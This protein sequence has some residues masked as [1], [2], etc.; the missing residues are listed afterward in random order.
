MGGGAVRQQRDVEATGQHDVTA[1]RAPAPI[2]PPVA[3]GPTVENRVFEAKKHEIQLDRE[4]EE[5]QMQ[6]VV[7]S[8]KDLRAR[9][10]EL[11]GRAE[12]FGDA[13]LAA[14]AREGAANLR[15]SAGLLEQARTA[16]DDGRL[17][18]SSSLTDRATLLQRAARLQEH[19]LDEAKLYGYESAPPEVRHGFDSLINT[20]GRMDNDVHREKITSTLDYIREHDALLNSGA[21]GMGDTRRRLLGQVDRIASIL[22]AGQEMTPQL[23]AEL[24]ARFRASIVPVQNMI[25]GLQ[26]ASAML[27]K[28]IGQTGKRSKDYLDELKE[29]K[30]ELEKLKKDAGEEEKAKAAEKAA[31]V[32]DAETEIEAAPEE[33]R[34]GL[35][36]IYARGL[37]S[38]RSGKPAAA[39]FQAEIAK[40]FARA[41]PAGRDM[42]ESISR[43]VERGSLSVQDG[44]GLLRREAELS[45]IE[46][47][48]AGAR[49]QVSKHTE[50]IRELDRKAIELL[51]KADA[52]RKRGDI[53][54]ALG[55]EKEA[56]GLLKE[57]DAKTEGLKRIAEMGEMLRRAG[58]PEPL[59]KAVDSAFRFIGTA[60]DWRG[61]LILRAGQ[62]FLDNKELFK[63]KNANPFLGALFRFAQALAGPKT[64][65]QIGGREKAEAYFERDLEP[66]TIE[67]ALLDAG[68]PAELIKAVKAAAGFMGTAQQWRGVMIIKAARAFLQ[69][70]GKL[71]FQKGAKAREGL[72][73]FIR[74]LASPDEDQLDEREMDRQFEDVL[75]GIAGIPREAPGRAAGG[76]RPVKAAAPAV[77]KAGLE[78]EY[79]E[80]LSRFGETEGIAAQVIAAAREAKK[81]IGT[82]QEWRAKLALET[83]ELYQSRKAVLSKPES[84]GVFKGICSLILTLGD[85]ARR[86]DGKKAQGFLDRFRLEADGLEKKARV[87]DTA[88]SLEEAGAP[89]EIAK[90]V[91]DA[92]AFAG[93]ADEWRL[94]LALEAA[95]LY[96]GK[97]NVFASKYGS[98]ALASFLNFVGAISDPSLKIDKDKA[99]TDFSAFSNGVDSL[100][101]DMINEYKRSFQ[102]HK[103]TLLK[104]YRSAPPEFRPAIDA[105]L[106]AADEMIGRLGNGENVRDDD[107]AWLGMRI[108][109]L[110]QVVPKIDGIKDKELRKQAMSAYISAFTVLAA[111]KNYREFDILIFAAEEIEG[112]GGKEFKRYRDDLV[113]RSAGVASAGSDKLAEETEAVVRL[114]SSSVS[115]EIKTVAAGRG[116]QTQEIVSPIADSVASLAD[117][118][119]KAVADDFYR[120]RATLNIVKEMNDFLSPK[121]RLD[122]SI[123]SGAET[124]WD[125]GLT[126]IRQGGDVPTALSQSFLAKQF[127]KPRLAQGIRDEIEGLSRALEQDPGKAAQVGQYLEIADK[128]SGYRENMKGL[129]KEAQ[130]VLGRITSELES[131]ARLIASGADMLSADQAASA[132]A[133]VRSSMEQDPEFGRYVQGFAEQNNIPPESAV[134]LVARQK[135]FSELT[136]TA[137]MMIK[138]PEGYDSVNG[139]QRQQYFEI[140]GL[141][142]DAMISGE[143]GR[144]GIYRDAA[145]TYTKLVRPADRDDLASV[146]REYSRGVLSQE[147]AGAYFSVYRERS[148]YEAKITDK[149]LRANATAYFDLAMVS[150]SS[151]NI[152]DH[153]FLMEM[154][155]GYASW[156][157]MDPADLG[158]EDRKRREDSLRFYEGQLGDFSRMRKRITDEGW[159]PADGDI[160]APIAGAI[161]IRKAPLAEALGGGDL[162]AGVNEI[163]RIR[164]EAGTRMAAISDI[165]FGNKARKAVGGNEDGQDRLRKR[166]KRAGDWLGSRSKQAAADKL[167]GLGQYFDMHSPLISYDFVASSVETAKELHS[168]AK[169]E[170]DEALGLNRQADEALAAGDAKNAEGLR[171]LAMAHARNGLM[172]DRK[173]NDI[174]DGVVMLNAGVGLSTKNRESGWLDLGIGIKTSIAIGRGFEAD[175]F[176][177]IVVR[178]GKEVPID[179]SHVPKLERQA[180]T[181]QRSGTQGVLYQQKVERTVDRGVSNAKKEIRDRN[182]TGISELIDRLIELRP[183][184]EEKASL[185]ATKKIYLE[186]ARSKD[187]QEAEKGINDLQQLYQDLAQSA[188]VAKG[189]AD[190]GGNEVT[191]YDAVDYNKRYWSVVG[192][193]YNEDFTGAARESE[194]TQILM[195][196]GFDLA[197]NRITE[198]RLRLE[199]EPL[200]SEEGPRVGPYFG[201]SALNTIGYS[202][203]DEARF[204]VVDEIGSHIGSFDGIDDNTKEILKR[205]IEEIR[206]MPSGP[207]RNGKVIDFLNLVR[208]TTVKGRVLFDPVGGGLIGSGDLIY[209]DAGANE[210]ELLRARGMA[211]SGDLEPAKDILANAEPEMELGAAIQREDN[212]RLRSKVM[213]LTI[214]K[215][216]DNLE[217]ELPPAVRA[218]DGRGKAE[219]EDFE[220]ARAPLLNAM[221][222]SRYR[223]ADHWAGAEQGFEESRD[224]I[225]KS[226]KIY[227]PTPETIVGIAYNMSESNLNMVLSNGKTYAQMVKEVETATTPDEKRDKA[228]E[229]YQTMMTESPSLVE[230]AISDLQKRRTEGWDEV[231]KA[232]GKP[233]AGG[234]NL[235]PEL[236][237]R[238]IHLLP[239]DVWKKKKLGNGLTYRKMMVEVLTANT[240][241]EKRRA[242]EELFKALLENPED[243]SAVFDKVKAR[244]Q[245]L[246]NI[247][248]DPAFFKPILAQARYQNVDQMQQQYKVSWAYQVS[249]YKKFDEEVRAYDNAKRG[250]IGQPDE[251][252]YVAGEAASALLTAASGQNDYRFFDL[253]KNGQ[254][255]PAVEYA[256]RASK[257]RPWHDF[258]YLRIHDDK[259]SGGARPRDENFGTWLRFI[260]YDSGQATSNYIIAWDYDKR[261]E[262]MSRVS[263]QE[264]DFELGMLGVKRTERGAQSAYFIND[265]DKFAAWNPNERDFRQ[266]ADSFE[267]FMNVKNEMLGTVFGYEDSWGKNEEESLLEHVG[268]RMGNF[269]ESGVILQRDGDSQKNYGDS[270]IAFANG[271][272]F[273]RKKVTI[274][275]GELA[276]ERFTYEDP[277]QTTKK[278]IKEMY[279]ERSAHNSSRMFWKILR[280]GAEYALS[281]F[282]F[283]I[284][285]AAATA[286]LTYDGLDSAFTYYNRAGGW[287]YMSGSQKGF[288]VFQ[289]GMAVLPAKMHLMGSGLRA[290]RLGAE[291]AELSAAELRTAGLG[292]IAAGERVLAWEGKILI[293]AGI[294]QVAVELPDMWRAY[295]RGEM[296]GLEIFMTGAQTVM[297][298]IQ[299]A[300]HA[301]RIAAMKET[302]L[303]T[304]RPRWRQVVE[305]LAFGEPLDPVKEHRIAKAY[306][307]V[308]REFNRLESADQASYNA[309]K[310]RYGV[311]FKAEEES[312]FLRKFREARESGRFVDFEHFAANTPEV[313][314][315]RYESVMYSV[316]GGKRSLSSVSEEEFVYLDARLKGRSQAEAMAS[317]DIHYAETS[318]PEAR[319]N[320]QAFFDAFVRM[321]RSPE[322][323]TMPER[324]YA[325]SRLKGMEPREAMKAYEAAKAELPRQTLDDLGRAALEREAAEADAVNALVAKTASALIG[326]FSSVKERDG[327]KVY[328]YGEGEYAIDFTEEHVDAATKLAYYANDYLSD[329]EISGVA[330]HEAIGKIP[331]RYREA[332]AGLAGDPDFAKAA[333]G[334][335]RNAQLRLGLE[336][337]AKIPQLASKPEVMR[338]AYSAEVLPIISERSLSSGDIS[339]FARDRRAEARERREKA[340]QLEKE[341]GSAEPLEAGSLRARA[342]MLKARA[343]ALDISAMMLER[344][345]GHREAPV[346]GEIPVAPERK[347]SA[348]GTEAKVVVAKDEKGSNTLELLVADSPQ[349]V[350]DAARFLEKNVPSDRPLSEEELAR[351]PF[352]YRDAAALMAGESPERKLLW[353]ADPAFKAEDAKKIGQKILFDKRASGLESELKVMEADPS[354]AEDARGFLAAI[355]GQDLPYELARKYMDASLFEEYEKAKGEK[356]A[357]GMSEDRAEILAVIEVMQRRGTEPAEPEP[358]AVP[359][360]LIGRYRKDISG[361]GS[362][363]LAAKRIRSEGAM[364]Q[365]GKDILVVAEAKLGLRKDVTPAD[366]AALSSEWGQDRLAVLDLLS[367]EGSKFRERFLLADPVERARI[368][369][370]ISSGM[371]PESAF[372]RISEEFMPA[373]S[374]ELRDYSRRIGSLPQ[375]ER[376][377]R[378]RD[379]LSSNE[380]LY[381]TLSALISEGTSPKMK[382]RVIAEWDRASLE[383]L[384]YDRAEAARKARTKG[385]KASQELALIKGTEKDYAAGVVPGMIGEMAAR[386]GEDP[387]AF[388][389]RLAKAYGDGGKKGQLAVI[390]M[391]GVLGGMAQGQKQKF[392]DQNPEFFDLLMRGDLEG[393]IN[394]L[395]GFRGLRIESVN[396]ELGARGSYSVKLSDGR[397]VFVKMES[398]E[399]ARFGADLAATQGLLPPLTHADDAAGRPLAYD[400]GVRFE[401]PAGGTAP[402]LQEFGIMEDVHDWAGKTVELKMPDGRREKVEVLSVAMMGPEV[403]G[404]SSGFPGDDPRNMAIT[405]FYDLARTPEGRAKLYSSWRAYIEMSRRALLIDRFDRNTEVIVV[406]RGDGSTEVLFQPIDMDFIGGRIKRFSDGALDLNAFNDDF[407]KATMGFAQ[408]LSKRSGTPLDKVLGE[409]ISAYEGGPAMASELPAERKASDDNRS[410]VIEGHDGKV[411]GFG[412]DVRSEGR[413]IGRTPIE[414]GGRVRVIER[415]DARMLMY[416]DELNPLAIHVGSAEGETAY[417]R[418]LLASLKEEKAQADKSAARRVKKPAQAPA[419]VERP[420]AKTPPM[421]KP[422]IAEYRPQ[423]KPAEVPPGFESTPPQDAGQSIYA[424]EL[425]GH[426]E[427]LAE[428]AVGLVRGDEAAVKRLASLKGHPA[429]KILERMVADI[430][431]DRHYIKAVQKNDRVGMERFLKF[432]VQAYAIRYAEQLA[433][434]VEIRPA[435]AVAVGEVLPPPRTTPGRRAAAPE[436]KAPGIPEFY[437]DPSGAWKK[438]E[439]LPPIRKA[440]FIGKVAEDYIEKAYVAGDKES[441]SMYENLP[442]DMKENFD[443]TVKR[444][445]AMRVEHGDETVISR[446]KERPD[447]LRE[448]VNEGYIPEGKIISGEPVA[449]DQIIEEVHPEAVVT[450]KGLPPALGP[451]TEGNVLAVFSSGSDLQT[452]EA[453]ARTFIGMDMQAQ[454]A[455]IDGL[456]SRGVQGEAAYLSELRGIAGESGDAIARIYG[457][458]K[459]A[460]IDIYA[461]SPDARSARHGLAKALGITVMPFAWEGTAREHR[462]WVSKPYQALDTSWDDGFIFGMIG[463]GDLIGA[464]GSAFPGARISYVEYHNGAVGAYEV[465]LAVPLP[466]GRTE[467]R[468][469]FVKRQDLRPDA[470]GAE[471]SLASGIPAPRVFTSAGGHEL[472]YNAPDG[473]VSRYGIMEDIKTFEGE[474]K[475]GGGSVKVRTVD[476]TALWDLDKSPLL[477]MF[478]SAD[479]QTRERFWDELGYTL[480]GSYATGLWDRHAGNARAMVLEV[481]NPGAKLDAADPASL[482][483]GDALRQKGYHVWEKDGKTLMFMIGGIDNDTGASFLAGEFNGSYDFSGMNYRYGMVDLHALFKRLAAIRG[484]SVEKLVWEAFG[485]VESGKL[486]GPLARGASRWMH[487]IGG[488][489]GYIEGMKRMFASHDG[490]GV[491]LG[492]PYSPDQQAR[493][494]QGKPVHIE[495]PQNGDP[496]TLIEF[497]DGRSKLRTDY[498][499][500]RSDVLSGFDPAVLAMFPD[501]RE[502]YVVELTRQALGKMPGIDGAVNTIRTGD[503]RTLAV[504][505]AMDPF[506]TQLADSGLPYLKAR[507]DVPNPADVPNTDPAGLIRADPGFGALVG[508]QVSRAGAIPVFESMMN[509]G[510]AFLLAQFGEVGRFVIATEKRVN[511]QAPKADIAGER[512]VPEAPAPKLERLADADAAM[513][514]L[515][516][517]YRAGDPEGIVKARQAYEDKLRLAAKQMPE[518]PV[519][520]VEAAA[521]LGD[522]PPMKVFEGRT[523]LADYLSRKLGGG[524]LSGDAL[525][526]QRLVD[527]GM[528]PEVAAAV[529]A[530]HSD[531]V[532]SAKIP[533][534]GGQALERYSARNINEISM[535]PLAERGEAMARFLIA[536]DYLLSRAEAD[537]RRA[538]AWFAFMEDNPN[539]V[540]Y[541]MIAKRGMAVSGEGIHF[542]EFRV[543]K[544]DAAARKDV[545]RKLAKK[546]PT[547]ESVVGALPDQWFA[548]AGIAKKDVIS[549]SD[550]RK[551]ASMLDSVLLPHGLTVT[552]KTGKVYVAEYSHSF[553]LDGQADLRGLIITETYGKGDVFDGNTAVYSSV[554]GKILLRGNRHFAEAGIPGAAIPKLKEMAVHE[555]QHLFDNAAG[556]VTGLSL[557]STGLG[558]RYLDIFYGRLETTAVAREVIELVRGKG[559]EGA[560]RDIEKSLKSKMPK[561]YKYAYGKVLEA[562]MTGEDGRPDP[563]WKVRSPEILALRVERLIDREYTDLVGIP[564][565]VLFGPNVS[566]VVS[567][568]IEVNPSMPPPIYSEPKVVVEGGSGEGGG[569]GGGRG[570]PPDG[571]RDMGPGF[572]GEKRRLWDLYNRYRDSRGNDPQGWQSGF[573]PHELDTI[574]AI[575]FFLAERSLPHS[576]EAVDF[577]LERMADMRTRPDSV[578]LPDDL[579]GM[580]RDF[581][582]YNKMVPAVDDGGQL[583]LMPLSRVPRAKLVRKIGEG[584]G[585]AVYE[586]EI[587]VGGRPRKVAVKVMKPP[588][589]DPVSGELPWSE[590]AGYFFDEV[591]R[592]GFL[593]ERGFGPGSYGMVDVGGNLAVA[594]DIVDGKTIG[595]M[596]PEEVREYVGQR[597]FDQLGSMWQKLIG[598]GYTIG[599]F[600]FAVLTRDQEIGGVN[601][602][603]GDVVFWDA[604]ALRSRGE[605]ERAGRTFNPPTAAERVA[606]AEKGRDVILFMEY[607]SA[608]APGSEEHDALV[609]ILDRLS[610]EHPPPPLGEAGRRFMVMGR[611]ARAEAAQ[612]YLDS[613]SDKKERARVE[614][615]L[616]SI[617][618]RTGV[619]ILGRI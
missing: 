236:V 352:A 372:R 466:D 108:G 259:L 207:D 354:L 279:E 153:E 254:S 180:Q 558:L 421:K 337:A 13:S 394:Q 402:L 191:F 179:P 211:L 386:R 157:G 68:A 513:A 27:E 473:S 9:A 316:A 101:E 280:I 86:V 506:A 65:R 255:V 463:N 123:R 453:A 195:R 431:L 438:A 606:E 12:R 302:G 310:K 112:H 365:A 601:R 602:R 517:A 227:S 142:A 440:E 537:P 178:E 413:R 458:R 596:R 118:P 49:P 332:A 70:R 244:N 565:S 449:S 219:K 315:A 57:A 616:R 599:D 461:R 496:Y 430:R 414:N 107:I 103:I 139:G 150:A 186:R 418:S 24:D 55:Y 443:D 571:P 501:G 217:N 35:S 92:G 547:F 299:A 137:D 154:A 576:A 66:K 391:L 51:K 192:H 396:F 29:L 161:L 281:P 64:D 510:D 296:S 237:R 171:A 485:D 428:L 264:T 251:H 311:S 604:G 250:D 527:I 187:R 362:D 583:G 370:L 138:P 41:P 446:L 242:G 20:D 145:F 295:K 265:N 170:T 561:Q 355:H 358:A 494:R 278:Y 553:T 147:V 530:K 320:E 341:A 378:M 441:A 297:P 36:V 508:V 125:R 95:G 353:E 74:R 376:E 91:R 31:F 146:C 502:V 420:G 131:K 439:A 200:I 305:G 531:G 114:L 385:E 67:A 133:W 545:K 221:K 584:A 246:R 333:R 2:R 533:P 471:Y 234:A 10:D 455:V 406:R 598:E 122:D 518:R 124:I 81:F 37:R 342:G 411:Y 189:Y 209:Y 102:T 532:Y 568:E 427:M 522:L 256:F 111:G 6:Y 348:I 617:E 514:D 159:K 560:G 445:L 432:D 206:K 613:L 504:I 525:Y 469:V 97:K 436:T 228:Q 240:D 174:V 33:M 346:G 149:R 384:R 375:A 104:M 409:M 512:V 534:G 412:Y 88:R 48:A 416:A 115:A 338:A 381:V 509:A 288:F 26:M 479:P 78:T 298:L 117:N 215:S 546:P 336:Y 291:A 301:Q 239:E 331:E 549:A 232:M 460:L 343:D 289:V 245:G 575:E 611:K 32:K 46:R 499:I 497:S 559:G 607:T 610:M 619:P 603:K 134:S 100:A 451:M 425:A 151:G 468:K 488:D 612:R 85:H 243:Y 287:D 15:E 162:D 292:W 116:G 519:A 106:K 249:M 456:L 184:G 349:E 556:Y 96:L 214:K 444:K 477:S 183:E 69:N 472:I 176:G 79:E 393:R 188:G 233:L 323:L 328:T 166:Y 505:D 58:A 204:V 109:K 16:W 566:G 258:S 452:R 526:V 34:E 388:Q 194:G 182:I 543:P 248:D 190:E 507:R 76:A 238:M 516:K 225:I 17:E 528:S 324:A 43:W 42:L 143:I 198:K 500:V 572:E 158:K 380:G 437:A 483:V 321:A 398:L 319:S 59:I 555:L 567:G 554:S 121:K 60:S 283:G 382:D 490:E 230:Y 136:A 392:I 578:L 141:S 285:G 588:I 120:A 23:A 435:E 309:Y 482:S 135:W 160:K 73:G 609:S 474:I 552:R 405:G 597:T 590:Q 261:K 511:P 164:T 83:I 110:E 586:A 493:I 19:T 615:M 454:K 128:I 203:M 383:G 270:L 40:E 223:Q 199:V 163:Q 271:T 618:S 63:G 327:K 313:K 395:Q 193:Y 3:T 484:V 185:I 487:E 536:T 144:A 347:S 216:A 98:Q 172:L 419:P 72:L 229:L 38:F 361:L 433:G 119:G 495:N 306:A 600:Q 129:P 169:A 503:G 303:P 614:G 390:D 344:E 481:E 156:A 5:L 18:E 605:I 542:S 165:E 7:P 366:A 434:V 205:Q 300:M 608:L 325:A 587:V 304:Y 498:E 326:E 247:P 113:R 314:M 197:G 585:G 30:E 269:H 334:V 218:D 426:P 515:M 50:E 397:R 562:M 294:T 408:E 47:G 450:Q 457:A 177:D 196:T 168:R 359:A 529:V 11:E 404:K 589:E 368:V 339:E 4:I 263:E 126:V 202:D 39:R 379:I 389:E 423:D 345:A 152:P 369:D 422:A 401:D 593:A 448:L 400:T 557:R 569:G 25:M 594:M 267:Q 387:R 373:D 351:M 424:Q 93:T 491:G 417:S 8:P 564:Y 429:G 581:Y 582:N 574:K 130:Q 231:E 475:V 181:Y 22:D 235:D 75:R 273:E 335:D 282:T 462:G 268:N 592:I 322:T 252:L 220:E 222:G 464:V 407:N 410:K 71:S 360:E 210:K 208:G 442:P 538:S 201:K 476:E 241:E 148:A 260:N 253:L 367:R 224:A 524:G 492:Y 350:K 544:A 21:P 77:K 363:S 371:S 340:A 276:E 167:S 330:P 364:S 52:A 99:E 535:L 308:S 467:M 61:M 89:P 213:R 80:A 1:V 274:G 28:A 551:A 579:R 317:V 520:E 82:D 329:V 105:A 54:K 127:L 541:A 459:D 173:A 489:R 45:R 356:T 155:V 573:M 563:R 275:E 577:A 486:D 262:Y 44:R 140:I 62:F 53:P 56:S 480:A 447:V 548:S 374:A 175:G 212:K 94:D 591:R 318:A 312:G 539:A 132:E 521:L 87:E 286:E 403:F 284:S 293:G 399:A 570:G 357:G 84:S 478:D 307:M 580:P 595:E 290:A 14:R 377:L 272:P 90:A 226:R 470:A 266:F 540:S 523:L 277:D 550:P 465:G 415:S 257:E